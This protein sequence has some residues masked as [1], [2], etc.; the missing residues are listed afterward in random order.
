[1]TSKATYVPGK[2]IVL[3][4]QGAEDGLTIVIPDDW[5]IAKM[6]RHLTELEDFLS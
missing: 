5:T 2:G 3:S 1:M 6:E 4:L